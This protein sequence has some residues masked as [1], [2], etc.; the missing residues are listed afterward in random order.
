VKL[1][2]VKNGLLEAENFFLVSNFGDFAASNNV[3]R[4]I[5]TGK[6]KLTS[7]NKIERLF[8]YNEFLIEVQKENFITPGNYSMIYLG[9][10]GYTFG[11]RDDEPNTQHKYWKILKQDKY[12][13]AYASTDG[14]NYINIGGMEFSEDI[15]KQGFMKYG[16]EDFILDDYKVYS[17]PYVT[18][19]NYPTGT[20]C[21]LYD[22]ENNLLTTRIFDDN[23]ECKIYL[24]R[25]NVEGHFV[26]KDSNGNVIGNDTSSLILGYGDVWVCSPYNFEIIYHGS[27][28]SNITPTLLQDLNELIVIKNVGSQDH[29]DLVIGTQSSSDDL[30]ELSLDGINYTNT[31][32]IDI[33]QNEEKNIYVKVT[34]NANNHNFS[35]RDFQ[36]I[37]NE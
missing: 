5:S 19:Q 16:T 4:D 24:N 20:I 33:V 3:T 8:N 13:Q 14:I 28:V 27:V 7:D 35:V 34:K 1:L 32:N 11:I 15:T 26:F 23:L 21:E 18:I 10:D 17:T 31:V 12:I 22:K 9:N 6:L 36:L 37:I 30:I 29:V 25:N 2:K